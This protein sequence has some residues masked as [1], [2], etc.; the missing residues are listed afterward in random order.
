MASIAQRRKKYPISSISYHILHR[1]EKEPIIEKQLFGQDYKLH[2]I[3]D[4]KG[5][6]VKI[7][8]IDDNI[9]KTARCTY[10]S[11]KY[12]SIRIYEDNFKQKSIDTKDIKKIYFKDEN[13]KEDE[14]PSE[15]DLEIISE[16][17]EYIPHD[18]RKSE[19]RSWEYI[20]EMKTFNSQFKKK[21]FIFFIKN[22]LYEHI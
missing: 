11:D 5:K 10:V 16:L 22:K 4:L 18:I 9:E 20:K 17:Y 14:C 13:P 19:K 6:K 15:K 3:E 7:V 21:D 2:T 12:I 8:K 1:I